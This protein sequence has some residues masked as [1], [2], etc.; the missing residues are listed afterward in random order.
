MPKEKI[1]TAKALQSLL[2][3]Y[4]YVDVSIPLEKLV[5]SAGKSVRGPVGP[6]GDPNGSVVF[7]TIFSDFFDLNNLYTIA[8]FDK[9]PVKNLLNY[10]L[11]NEVDNSPAV[12]CM[13]TPPSFS[14]EGFSVNNITKRV[15]LPVEGK[16]NG[17]DIYCGSFVR[18]IVNFTNNS[19]NAS[20]DTEKSYTVNNTFNIPIKNSVKNAT[21]YLDS[22]QIG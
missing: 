15:F 10:C 21:F 4:T 12:D 18:G 3:Y 5:G 19:Y 9:E 16:I 14:G 7:R 22:F 1:Y 13:P 17:N 2:S 8:V 11:K 6:T 20:D